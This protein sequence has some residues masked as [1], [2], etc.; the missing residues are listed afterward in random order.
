MT[1]IGSGAGAQSPA[2]D[3]INRLYTEVGGR[4]VFWMMRGDVLAAGGCLDIHPEWDDIQ[5]CIITCWAFTP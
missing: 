1:A 3:P 5:V 4:R 2:P